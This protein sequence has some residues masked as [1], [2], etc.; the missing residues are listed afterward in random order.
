MDIICACLIDFTHLAPPC[1]TCSVLLNGFAHSRLRS[2]EYAAGLPDLP[3]EKAHKVRIGNALADVAAA[4]Y[5]AQSAASNLVQLE[6]PGK[7][8]MP[9]YEPIQKVLQKD[10]VGWL[11][12]RCVRRWRS[13][14]E[15]AGAL[16]SVAQGETKD[17]CKMP[18]MCT[19][20]STAWQER[21]WDG[22]VKG[23]KRVLASVGRSNCTWVEDD[24]RNTSKEERLGNLLTGD[25]GSQ[26]CDALRCSGRLS[27][28]SVWG[29]VA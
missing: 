2:S 9:A 27:F 18:R 19:S 17:R 4:I 20:C 23:G 5:G 29:T 24:H 14:D 16:H 10:G 21:G 13:L 1:S 22:L 15:A 3:P 12:A 7:S 8:L 25:D 26:Q 28:P 11:S 6:Q